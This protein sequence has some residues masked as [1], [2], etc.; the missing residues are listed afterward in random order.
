MIDRVCLCRCWLV[1]YTYYYSIISRRFLV[2]FHRRCSSP[3]AILSKSRR[4]LNCTQRAV[5]R[6]MYWA[7]STA[8]QCQNSG[9][10]RSLQSKNAMAPHGVMSEAMPG[11][12]LIEALTISSPSHFSLKRGDYTKSCS[13]A[14]RPKQCTT[15]P[16]VMQCMILHQVMQCLH[17]PMIL[18]GLSAVCGCNMAG[19]PAGRL[20][21]W[22]AG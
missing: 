13:T 12:P 15:S 4:R 14:I 16:Q 8:H 17:R 7:P 19:W 2:L 20:A 5:I 22:L 3:R 6:A 9:C 10:A 21:C 18:T 11:Q 1:R